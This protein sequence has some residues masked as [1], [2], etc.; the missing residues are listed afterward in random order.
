MKKSCKICGKIKDFYSWEDNTC[1]SCQKEKELKRIQEQIS[2]GDEDVDTYSTD[3]VICPYCGCA[4]ET[5]LG[6]EDFPEI[7]ED[8]DHES[9]VCRKFAMKA[10]ITEIELDEISIENNQCKY[11]KDKSFIVELPC[12]MG[13]TVYV[14]YDNPYGVVKTTTAKVEIYKE[15]T[16]VVFSNR[17]QFTV[18]DNDWRVYK[19]AVF[20]SR[21]EAE[22]AL[23]EREING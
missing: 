23:E 4:H 11:F 2:L 9:E 21:E 16:T 20:S 7:Y 5:K 6:Y 10:D 14:C 17:S 1:Y 19:N 13:D 15:F 22:R 18:W 8:G 3:Y 12:R